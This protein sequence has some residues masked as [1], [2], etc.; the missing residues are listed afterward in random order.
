MM[1][2]CGSLDA[3]GSTPATEERAENQISRAS[4]AV[5]SRVRNQ[6]AP[7]NPKQLFHGRTLATIGGRYALRPRRGHQGDLD[8]PVAGIP[9][10]LGDGGSVSARPSAVKRDGSPTTSTSR[11]SPS[12][13]A[14]AR[15]AS[16]RETCSVLIGT[17]SE[18]P[19]TRTVPGSGPGPR[20]CDAPTAQAGRRLLLPEAKS[21]SPRMMTVCP[22]AC[23]PPRG[24]RRR[25]RGKQ[26]TQVILAGGWV[27]S[28]RGLRPRR[29]GRRALG[30]STTT[31]NPRSS[32]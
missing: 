7:R 23:P 20:R 2:G 26:D 5:P 25:C 3:K 21:P 29:W 30:R 13:H 19:V 28:G 14:P 6:R 9:R 27:S 16:S 31:S 24:A 1:Y 11:P 17:L 18:C 32:C 15:G 4:A 8:P 22:R 12:P 10:I